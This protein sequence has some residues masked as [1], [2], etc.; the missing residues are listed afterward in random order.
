MSQPTTIIYADR[1]EV[2]RVGLQALLADHQNDVHLLATPAGKT[3]L[4]K[5]ME[6]EPDVVVFELDFTGME[7]M[8]I[9]HWL[10][11]NYPG[12]RRL[13]LTM[14][15]NI[16]IA[17]ELAET[18]VYSII[19]KGCSAAELVSRIK[20]VAAGGADFD[21]A[22]GEVVVNR[23]TYTAEGDLG[24]MPRK[25]LQMLCRGLETDAISDMVNRSRA[26]VNGYR[27]MIAEKVGSKNPFL[28][29]MYAVCY[30]LVDAKDCLS[31]LKKKGK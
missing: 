12:C 31:E 23:I 20:K 2:Y 29:A 3:A 8:E 13:A 6:L 14:Y 26:S 16:F 21:T 28:Q 30:G 15:D 19:K 11:E 9:C 18:G 24:A 27:A 1:C 4:I 22:F 17:R 25:V 7:G 5:A 10:A